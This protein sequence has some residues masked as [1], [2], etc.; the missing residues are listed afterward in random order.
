M[1][2]SLGV[3]GREDPHETLTQLIHRADM[4]MYQAKRQGRNQT[5][6]AA[7][8]HTVVTLSRSLA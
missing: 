7:A 6:L 5:V 1:T 8:P 3:A 4:A 2:I